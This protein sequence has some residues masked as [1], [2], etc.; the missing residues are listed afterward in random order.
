MQDVMTADDLKEVFS[1][2]LPLMKHLP[3]AE[4]RFFHVKSNWPDTLQEWMAYPDEKTRS[5]KMRLS[6]PMI[7]RLDVVYDML[8][9]IPD[10]DLRATVLGK[11]ILNP[12]IANEILA[13][14]MKVSVRTVRRRYN[15]GIN[16][17]L[18]KVDEKALTA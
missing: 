2:Y 10:R 6:P 9:L 16:I 3:P 18:E 1:F 7:S 8:R 15:D 14:R 4:N 11:S 12:R 5:P 13:K 17:V